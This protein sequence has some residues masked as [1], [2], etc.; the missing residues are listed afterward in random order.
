MTTIQMWDKVPGMCNETPVLEYFPAENK[1]TDATVVVFPGG[2]Y[3]MRASH[4]GKGYAEYLNSIG[5]DAFVC[6][7]R[8]SPHRF[9]LPLLDARR[10]VRYVRANAE[11]FNI[12]PDKVAVMGS[13]AGG[14][15]AALVSTYNAPIDFEDTDEIDKLNPIP[16]ASILCYAVIHKPDETKV[17][18]FG[19]YLNLLGEGCD[20]YDNYSPDMLVNDNTPPAFIWHTSDDNVVNVINSYLYATALRQHGIKH[21]MHVFPHGN[22]GLGLAGNMP[23]VAQWAGLLENWFVDLGWMKK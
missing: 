7:Y 22:H 14:H 21:E 18:H 8:V 16:N 10:A 6:E 13:S 20:D 4:E 9:P 5:M 2:G 23:H 15:L 11:K 3:T 1:K 12:D 19:S 17:T